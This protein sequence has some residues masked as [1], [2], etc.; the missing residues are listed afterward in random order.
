VS[1]GSIMNVCVTAASLAYEP[2]GAI[3]MRHFTLAAKREL[4]KLGHQYDEA[5]FATDAPTVTPG[6][7]SAQ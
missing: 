1:G 3:G 6:T 5:A 7:A 4:Q 2:G